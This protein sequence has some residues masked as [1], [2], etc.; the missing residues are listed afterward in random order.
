MPRGCIFDDVTAGSY[1][2]P[3]GKHVAPATLHCG[4]HPLPDRPAAPGK[5]RLKLDVDSGGGKIMSHR[6]SSPRDRFTAPLPKNLAP[7][8]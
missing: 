2:S 1:L 8:S 3:L 5:M 6:P 7:L 4:R